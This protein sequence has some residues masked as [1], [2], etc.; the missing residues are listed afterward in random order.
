MDKR[1]FSKRFC[2]LALTLAVILCSLAG[3]LGVAALS[4]RYTRFDM[5]DQGYYTLS[6]ESRALLAGLEKDVELVLLAV[7]GSED[8]SL[9]YL[10]QRYADFS[11]RVKLRV[12]DPVADQELA[13]EY[14]PALRYSNSVAVV[15]EGQSCLIEPSELYESDYGA[16]MESGNTADI[17]S[18][19]R[20]EK[21]VSGALRY[22]TA[23]ELPKLYLLHGHGETA[24]G[25]TISRALRE[26]GIRTAELDLSAS[27]VPADA[28]ALLIHAPTYDISA[29]ERE[30]LAA[31]LENGG[32]MI[33]I[34]AYSGEPLP[35]LMKLME[36]YGCT[37]GQGLVVEQDREHYA[38]G[39]FDC[40]IPIVEE[41]ELTSGME[42]GS[43]IMPGS[44]P[45]LYEGR[46]DVTVTPLLTTSV[47]AYASTDLGSVG[48][49]AGDLSGP[50]TVAAQ[51]EKGE[52][53]V[54]WFASGFMLDE[55]YGEK[56]GELFVAAARA[57]CGS[58]AM[59]VPVK[60]QSAA[61]EVLSL[62]G[63][64]SI[65][66]G[67]AFTLLIPLVFVVTGAVVLIRRRRRA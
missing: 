14:A 57:L 47:A 29:A 48:K 55:N 25:D 21:A 10:L 54:I 4:G 18:I 28:D 17:M 44:Q 15:S 43:V 11:R 1:K 56:N 35:E 40:L 12:V 8:L 5:S 2:T 52:S 19:F 36:P 60:A 20:A 34:T 65:V 24:L 3:A 6:E 67:A 37:L 27:E 38:Y 66:L 26:N 61:G 50:L 30:K 22:V 23:T 64:Q 31:Y 45:I 58:E 33:L 46:D 62:T 9:Q 16:Y 51:I 13:A 49:K 41:H 53:R 32:Q 39:Y 7:E 42:A 63:P 59:D